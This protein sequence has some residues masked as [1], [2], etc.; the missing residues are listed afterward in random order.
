M[1]GVGIWVAQLHISPRTAEKIRGVHSL[2]PEWVR[3][4]I[5]CRAGLVATWHVHPERGLRA[6]IE[7]PMKPK[8]ILVVLYPVTDGMTQDE[9]HLGS[10]YPWK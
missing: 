3:E 10:A 1:R 6:L 8:R 7:L 9:Y 2:D 4:Q 5:E